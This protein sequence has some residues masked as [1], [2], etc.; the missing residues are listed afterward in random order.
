MFLQQRH[1]G[2]VGGEFAFHGVDDE[3]AMDAGTVQ[4]AVRVPPEG[5]L[6]LGQDDVVG[7]VVAWH[8]GALRDELGAV[9]PRVPGLVH[10]VPAY[11]CGFEFRDVALGT[12]PSVPK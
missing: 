7:E 2:F 8:D 12:T 9:E 1:L 3:G 5:A 10:A 4:L 11:I 6:L